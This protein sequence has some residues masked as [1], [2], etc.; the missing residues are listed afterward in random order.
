MLFCLHYYKGFCG[1]FVNGKGLVLERY[2][3]QI[4]VGMDLDLFKSKLYQ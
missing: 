1:V 4:A 3:N 2:F